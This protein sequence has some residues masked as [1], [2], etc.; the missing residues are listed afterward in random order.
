[1]TLIRGYFSKEELADITKIVKEKNVETA[2]KKYG[3]GVHEFY[4]ARTDYPELAEAIKKGQEL[5]SQSSDYAIALNMFRTLTHAELEEITAIALKGGNKA[6]EDH[7]KCSKSILSKCRKAMPELDAAL[8]KGLSKIPKGSPKGKKYVKE[9]RRPPSNLVDSAFL[10]V[11]GDSASAIA[12][13][14]KEMEERKRVEYMKS[15]RNGDYDNM[16]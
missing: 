9:A 1:M 11:E 12:R 16:I 10:A 6:V 3:F 13:F 14:R 4:A 2:S 15:I 8:T 7:Y 5:R